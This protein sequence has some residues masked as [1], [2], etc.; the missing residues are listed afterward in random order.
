MPTSCVGSA[1]A[2]PGAEG[3]GNATPGGR[4]GQVIVVTNL[5]ADGPGSFREAILTAGPR[6]IVFAVSGVI[7]FEGA[8]IELGEEHSFLTVAGQ[9]SPGGITLRNVT[10]SSYHAGFHDAIFRFFRVRGPDSYDNLSFATTYNLVF[11][12]MDFSGGSDECFDITYSHDFTVQWSTIT[13]S[14]SGSG[15]QNYGALIA[16]KPTSRVSIHHNLMAHHFGR[17]AAQIH[18]GGDNP[19]PEDGAQIDF[20]NNVAYNCGFQQVLRVDDAPPTGLFCNLIGNYAKSGPDTPADSMIF[21]LSGDI[22]IAD[23]VYEGQSIILSPFFDG[24]QLDMPFDYPAITTSSA[25]DAYDQVL[26]FAG[27]WPRDA[28]VTRTVGEVMAGTGTL[29]KQDDEL[30]TGGPA[31]PADGDMD[32]MP[33]DWETSMGLNPASAADASLLAESGYSNVEVYLAER[34]AAIVGQ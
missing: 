34:A 14:T 22:H 18:Y 15:S 28:M 9:S 24:N 13:N 20:R 33:D 27:S 21:G 29:G 4:G 32:G 3:F 26:A 2:F 16:Y 10:L 17:C 12:H 11:D 19:S 8:A 25:A 30:L 1:C 5:N 31:A 6:I 23:N 7:D